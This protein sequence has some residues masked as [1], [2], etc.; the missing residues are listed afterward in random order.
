MSWTP[1]GCRVQRWILPALCQAKRSQ[2]YRLAFAELQDVPE[3]E[4]DL[5]LDFTPVKVKVEDSG[6][7]NGGY[8]GDEE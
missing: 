2:A 1:D 4:N 8:G 6:D 3:P 7:I 5:A